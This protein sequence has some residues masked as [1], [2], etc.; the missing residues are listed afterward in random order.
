LPQQV[1][2][3]SAI[4]TVMSEFENL[5]S[6]ESLFDLDDLC[7]IILG[8]QFKR[9]ALQFPDEHLDKCAQIYQYMSK[10][11]QSN[12]CIELFIIGDSTFGSSIDDISAQHVDTE[13]LVY[14]GSD[15]SSSGTMPVIIAP[16]KKRLDVDSVTSQLVSAYRE[17]V[18]EDSESHTAIL[19]YDPCFAHHMAK[20]HECLQSA[21]QNVNIM[22]AQLPACA[23]LKSWNVADSKAF[24]SGNSG[25]AKLGGLVVPLEAQSNVQTT[26]F[27]V[28]ARQE[29]LTSISLH[30]SQQVILSYNSV[31]D[32][33]KAFKGCDLKEYRE[34]IGGYL[35]VKD[36]NIIGIIIGSMVRNDS[37]RVKFII[38][39]SECFHFCS[40]P[41]LAHPADFFTDHFL[42]CRS[43][44]VCLRMSHSPWLLD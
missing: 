17:N 22:L 31:E 2:G 39:L 10:R 27:Y 36:A 26:V 41:I 21:L 29:Q 32:Q 20:L 11:L 6:I 35:R 24:R 28:G 13:L 44:R 43:S 8:N 5:T 33:V 18:Q 40:Y 4:S 14:F 1:A 30:M 15:L 42:L 7:H 3:S 12:D 9:V 25:S 38:T 37:C 19:A 23:N 16:I 34:R